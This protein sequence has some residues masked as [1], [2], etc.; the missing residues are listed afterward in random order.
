MF[1]FIWFSLIISAVANNIS[2]WDII[3][4]NSKYKFNFNNQT[5]IDNICSSIKINDINKKLSLCD[6]EFFYD[7]V[8]S[9]K[10]RGVNVDIGNYTETI[11]RYETKQVSVIPSVD[12]IIHNFDLPNTLLLVY[13]NFDNPITTN[14]ISPLYNSDINQNFSKPVI[15]N[16]P[17]DNDLQSFY[18]STPYGKKQGTSPFVTAIYETD[19]TYSSTGLVIGFTE[20]NLWKTGI[21]YS[22]NKI[23]SIIGLS[24]PL[25]TRDLHSHG[26]VKIIKTPVLSIGYYDNWMDG[27]EKYAD[28]IES[29]NIFPKKKFNKSLAGWDSWGLTIEGYGGASI[30]D[31]TRA[32]DVLSNLRSKNLGDTQIISIDAVYW[33]N[34]SQTDTWS[35]Y[36]FKN[37]QSS[38]SYSIPFIVWNTNQTTINC[39]GN[40]CSIGEDN[41]WLTSD[42]IVKDINGNKVVPFT[43]PSESIRDPT[44]PHTMCYLNNTFNLIKKYNISII[45][46]DFVNY[47]AVE[48]YRYNMT[49]APTGISAYNYA[50]QLLYKLWG[51]DIIINYGIT[52]PLPI[53]PGTYI[54]RQGCDQ[55][56]GGV[57]YSMNQYAG[58]WW[59]NKFYILNPDLVTFQGNYW[60]RPNLYNLTH[61]FS[62]DSISRIAKAVVYGGFL[63]N[64][65]NL[66]NDTN[67]G[68]VKKFLGNEKVNKM[69]SKSKLGIKDS[70]FRALYWRPKIEFIPLPKSIIAPNIYIRLNSN[71]IDIVIFNYI[72]FKKTFTIDMASFLNKT[73]SSC[74]NIWN[75][76]IIT[77]NNKILSVDIPRTSSILLNCK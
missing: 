29:N 50:L 68:I 35:E 13:L 70:H 33:L 3:K 19:A 54:R 10:N 69:W 71:D 6:Q 75:N 8:M 57:E 36:V 48:G 47:A 45:K 18:S 25:I 38:G 30:N 27:M 60:F 23:N 66:S 52:L 26:D 51:D 11:I 64:G 72:P 43:H 55:M 14:W 56:F 21:Q 2:N 63:Q 49:L 65:D 15:L 24:N 42:I 20:H 76:K 7:S 46:I 40:E 12:F 4:L 44:H 41:C 28:L 77:I 31:L 39:N 17:Y 53:A 67:V 73:Y 58:G 1:F 22:N 61:I 62:M 5:V 16:V 32:S 37:N 9:S 74:E 34:S 59:L